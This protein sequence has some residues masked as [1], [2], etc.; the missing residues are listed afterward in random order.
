RVGLLYTEHPSS[1][2][3]ID[4]IGDHWWRYSEYV[5]AFI[6]FGAAL[7]ALCVAAAPRLH[8]L[9]KIGIS[10][11]AIYVGSVVLSIVIGGLYLAVRVRPNELESDRAY[12]GLSINGTRQA[13]GLDKFHEQE[14]NPSQENQ[15]ALTAQRSALGD[16]RLWDWHALQQT[17]DQEQALRPYYLF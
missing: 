6:A 2:V 8:S 4:Y 9:R 13:F 12:I 15:S 10:A 17:L 14:Y 11:V 7:I 16:V 5:L 1:F 3:G